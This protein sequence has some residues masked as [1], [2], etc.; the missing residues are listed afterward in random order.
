MSEE[1]KGPGLTGGVQILLLLV[2]LALL[3][4]TNIDTRSQLASVS[5]DLR[6]ARER[7]GRMEAAFGEAHGAHEGEAEEADPVAEALGRIEAKLT[8]LEAAAQ[9]A[10]AHEEAA[11]E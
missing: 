6:D 11:E 3:I 2:V 7:L 1:D 4:W 8:A 10:H 5:A 9:A